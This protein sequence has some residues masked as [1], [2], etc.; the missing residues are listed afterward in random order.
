MSKNRHT[1]KD[2][3]AGKMIH[4]LLSALVTLS[5]DRCLFPS[6]HVV[7]YN[8]LTPAPGDPNSLL[9][10]NGTTYTWYT[11]MHAGKNTNRTKINK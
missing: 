5:E 10:P 11:Y 1:E 2:P 7:A 8:H 3:R 6:T 4:S 9:A